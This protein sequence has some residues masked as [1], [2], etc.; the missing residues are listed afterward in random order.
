[1]TATLSGKSISANNTDPVVITEN[2][3]L[4]MSYEVNVDDVQKKTQMMSQIHGIVDQYK[5]VLRNEDGMT[6]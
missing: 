2:F 4:T 1:M 5:P 6:E 3:L